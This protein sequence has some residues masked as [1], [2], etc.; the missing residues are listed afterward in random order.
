MK[1]CST[2]SV[3]DYDRKNEDIDP[4]AASAEYELEKRVERMDVFEVELQK[5]KYY[6]SSSLRLVLFTRV[7]S[8]NSMLFLL[9]NV[10][11]TFEHTFS[12]PIFVNMLL[13][14]FHE[15]FVPF[16]VIDTNV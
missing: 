15:A 1:V 14:R 10:K 11:L 8:T 13:G 6:N 2:Y 3:E 5:G 9:Y 7:T 16:K 4:M 12:F